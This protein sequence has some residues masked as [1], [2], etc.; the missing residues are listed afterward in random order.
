MSIRLPKSQLPKLKSV[1]SS[2]LKAIGGSEVADDGTITLWV[3][4]KP[5]N[6]YRYR[7]VP[8]S[9]LTSLLDANEANKRIGDKQCSVGQL[10]HLLVKKP[11]YKYDEVVVE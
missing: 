6:L 5:G 8:A 4:F 11:G 2:T 7:N 3:K 1:K 10:F 9:V